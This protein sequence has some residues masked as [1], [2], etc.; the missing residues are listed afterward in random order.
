MVANSPD[1]VLY[2]FLLSLFVW[3]LSA[4]GLAYWTNFWAW[5]IGGHGSLSDAVTSRNQIQQSR[6]FL[7]S[8]YVLPVILYFFVLGYIFV[9]DG[10]MDVPFQGSQVYF[11]LCF[12]LSA[13]S[14]MILIRG[15]YKFPL[16]RSYADGS[17][18]IT[19]VTAAR[20]IEFIILIV[21]L[22]FIGL[23][24]VINV[25]T[26]NEY[27]YFQAYFPYSDYLIVYVTFLAVLIVNLVLVWATGAYADWT[28]EVG[29]EQSKP[30][31]EDFV[32]FEDKF[33][34]APLV[35]EIGAVLVA[36]MKKVS[37]AQLKSEHE[38]AVT[39]GK[40][41]LSEKNDFHGITYT[42]R[43]NHIRTAGLHTIEASPQTA[44][45]FDINPH[46]MAIREINT[47][48]HH[49]VFAMNANNAS[50]LDYVSGH[51]RT[52]DIVPGMG[53]IANTVRPMVDS[54]KINLQA[55]LHP[56]FSFAAYNRA[57]YIEG[58]VYPWA[59]EVV[60]ITIG[61]SNV[62]SIVFFM[63][64][65]YI[66]LLQNTVSAIEISMASVVVP[67]FYSIATDPSYF[68]EW[69]YLGTLWTWIAVLFYGQSLNTSSAYAGDKLD[70]YTNLTLAG[71]VIYASENASGMVLDYSVTFDAFVTLGLVFTTLNLFGNLIGIVA[72]RGLCGNMIPRRYFTSGRVSSK[73]VAE[74]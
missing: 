38:F 46:N 28:G 9:G 6:Y 24:N 19:H 21:L 49:R 60:S 67:A 22:L 8:T 20:F 71:N 68:L 42:E 55:E 74:N 13:M 43:Q 18:E 63:F 23:W 36:D 70:L 37:P 45:T 73:A 25:G 69:W 17:T 1:Q 26:Y 72:S 61:W 32:S 16:G 40:F 59:G 35:P 27:E 10:N 29:R 54:S 33:F 50:V 48:D 31:K 51:K 41:G 4:L 52:L 39:K 58:M 64:V 34:T 53:R 47:G 44:N 14:L 57:V 30:N 12:V 11:V 65:S 2:T 3:A 56:N 5:T 7:S 62:V 66:V 15:I